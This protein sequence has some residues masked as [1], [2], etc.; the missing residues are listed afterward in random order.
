MNAEY[1]HNGPENFSVGR[2][3]WGWGIVKPAVKRMDSILA[4]THTPRFVIFGLMLDNLRLLS[5]GT[6][7]TRTYVV[8]GNAGTQRSG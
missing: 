3:T 2:G 7:N 4:F 6:M 1:T 8:N 5:S